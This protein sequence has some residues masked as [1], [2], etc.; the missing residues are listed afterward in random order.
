MR[1]IPA[2]PILLCFL[3]TRP[4][5][6]AVQRFIFPLIRKQT[7]EYLKMVN[8]SNRD[9][10]HCFESSYLRVV[11]METRAESMFLNEPPLT[12]YSICRDYTLLQRWQTQQNLQQSH[13]LFAAYRYPIFHLVY[14]GL[15]LAQHK[16]IKEMR[17]D[18]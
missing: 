4:V 3:Q 17:G 6:V 11:G 5:N 7:C 18:F 9:T 8:I 13:Q 1:V 15:A 16:E 2:F 14:K 10:H 12:L